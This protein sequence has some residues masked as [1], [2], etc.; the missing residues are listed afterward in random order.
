[1]LGERFSND[2]SGNVLYGEIDDRRSAVKDSGAADRHDR[3]EARVTDT[4]EL[5]IT[6]AEIVGSYNFGAETRRIIGVGLRSRLLSSRR[7]GGGGAA[8]RCA[9]LHPDVRQCI[10]KPGIDGQ[11][12]SV[13]DLGVAR[14][15]SI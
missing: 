1:M 2:H 6:S 7:R 11:P 10:N 12:R 15:L 14:C 5:C 9:A 4:I 13:K 8:S 3:R